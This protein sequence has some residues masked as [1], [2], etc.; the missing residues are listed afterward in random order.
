MVLTAIV[1]VDF[2]MNRA[3]GNSAV[4]FRCREN[5]WGRVVLRY[6]QRSNLVLVLLMSS[7]VG[8]WDKT[9]APFKKYLYTYTPHRL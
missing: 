8:K 2:W 7:S 4:E 1:I 6:W 3:E 5:L 9:I